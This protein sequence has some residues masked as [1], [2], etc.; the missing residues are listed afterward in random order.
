MSNLVS[1]KLLSDCETW[2]AHS[3]VMISGTNQNSG[4]LGIRRVVL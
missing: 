3:F 1:S 4:Q 2:A